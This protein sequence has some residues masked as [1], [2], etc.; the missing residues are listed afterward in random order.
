MLEKATKASD[1]GVTKDYLIKALLL[2]PTG[3]GKTQSSITVP[4][5]EGDERSILVLN[6]DGRAETLAG[7]PMVD[8]LDLPEVSADS[9]KAWD[10]L[11]TARR[12]LTYLAKKCQAEDLEFP[13]LAIIEDGLTAMARVCMNSALTLDPKKGLGGAPAQQHWMPQITWLSKHIN[14][15]RVL[16]C[17]YVLTGHLDLEK[18]EDLGGTKLLPKITKSLRTELPG[19]FNE[20]YYCHRAPG[21]GGMQYLW[22]TK[23]SGNLEY[24]K[25]TLNNLGDYWDDPIVL[26]FKHPP[27]GFTDLFQRRFK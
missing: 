5:A 13:Y 8:I 25:S 4:R 26:D 17:H 14:G 2:G 12:E 6:L 3:S 18:D 24:F 27:V 16:P 1:I 9:P 15:M 10:A 11:E 19:W 7:L 22:I 21:E 23:G 20:C